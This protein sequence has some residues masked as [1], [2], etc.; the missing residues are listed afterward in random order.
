MKESEFNDLAEVNCLQGSAANESTIYVRFLHEALDGSRLYAAAVLDADSVSCTLIELLS[1]RLADMCAN[2]LSLLESSRLACANSPD[3]L[4]SDN[5]LSNFISLEAFESSLDL[6][7]NE[8]K[9]RASFADLEGLAAADD[10]RDA[11]SKSSRIAT[12]YA[13]RIANPRVFFF[14]LNSFV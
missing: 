5:E 14:S 1:N 10:R 4:V 9:V 8:V 2:F 7:S 3:R 6:A 11:S 12:R 13:R